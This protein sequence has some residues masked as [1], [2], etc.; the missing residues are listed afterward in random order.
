M[1]FFKTYRN[2]NVTFDKDAQWYYVMNVQTREILLEVGFNGL[3]WDVFFGKGA[4]NQAFLSEVVL[5]LEFL[6]KTV[7]IKNPIC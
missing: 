3:E 1:N 7:A 6:N 4:C 5:M 2:V